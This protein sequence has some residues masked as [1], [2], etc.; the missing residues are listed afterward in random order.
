MSRTFHDDQLLMSSPPRDFR[1]MTFNGSARPRMNSNNMMS[2]SHRAS[3]FSTRTLCVTVPHNML[4]GSASKRPPV[5]AISF[6]IKEP[7]VLPDLP[8]SNSF[9]APRLS[10]YASFYQYRVTY[11]Q[12][13]PWSRY[14][15]HEA[16]S[17]PPCHRLA[18]R[19][20]RFLK[21]PRIRCLAQTQILNRP[22]PIRGIRKSSITRINLDEWRF[23][24]N[25]TPP[26]NVR[27]WSAFTL[28][29]PSTF[30][31]P[32]WRIPKTTEY[33]INLFTRAQSEWS[34]PTTSRSSWRK[35]CST[36]NAETTRCKT[37]FI[38]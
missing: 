38:R 2:A 1:E 19:R 31:Q 10:T 8:R 5:F 34:V 33:D 16:C 7:V 27:S 15:G 28:Y 17:C 22:T 23:S 3:S 12:L 9:Y 32:R 14:P 11:R 35:S 6:R 18:P 29:F 20:K 30:L 13:W 36:S 25:I 37:R 21:R 24:S 26:I 4:I